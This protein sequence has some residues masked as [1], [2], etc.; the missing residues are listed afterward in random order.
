V[1]NE[2]QGYMKMIYAQVNKNSSTA[3]RPF[4]PSDREKRY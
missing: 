4:Q 1:Q 3:S 2:G